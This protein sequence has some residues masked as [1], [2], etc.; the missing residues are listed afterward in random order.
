MLRIEFF[1][2]VLFSCGLLGERTFV[3]NSLPANVSVQ[4]AL[5]NRLAYRSGYIKPEYHDLSGS[6][7]IKVT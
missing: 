4:P 6:G 7:H 3:P 2:L 5:D 1:L